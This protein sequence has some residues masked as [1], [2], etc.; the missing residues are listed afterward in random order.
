MGDH[1]Q[2]VKY[3]LADVHDKTFQ[4]I[5]FNAADR[6]THEIGE[7]VSVWLE[8]TV[9]EWQGRRTVEGRLLRMDTESE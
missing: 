4:L 5:A 2:H 8:L 1:G 9:N 7:R 6:Y 3:T